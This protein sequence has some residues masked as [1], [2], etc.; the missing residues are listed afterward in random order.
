MLC[1]DVAKYH[2][3]L[4]SDYDDDVETDLKLSGIDENPV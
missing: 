1:N 4:S 3:Q 2:V